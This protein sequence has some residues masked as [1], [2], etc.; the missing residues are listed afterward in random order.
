M[1]FYFYK[2]GHCD[3]GDEVHRRTKS[4]HQIVLGDSIILF[5]MGDFTSVNLFLTIITSAYV[6]L[7]GSFVPIPGGSGGLEYGFIAFFGN[8]VSG[9]KLTAA[10]L[11]WR[12]ITYY[13][14]IIAGAVIMNI[15]EKRN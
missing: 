2:I 7:I 3:F 4:F 9:G 13:L 1:P 14:G 11:I 6:M 12:F 8:F 5:A 10:M 15:K